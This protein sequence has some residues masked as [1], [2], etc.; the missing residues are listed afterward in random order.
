[1]G[2]HYRIYPGPVK[3]KGD[4]TINWSLPR[5][6][7]CRGVVVIRNESLLE[8]NKSSEESNKHFYLYSQD[9]GGGI[10]CYV[11]FRKFLTHFLWE[12]GELF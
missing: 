2:R 1:M 4:P 8:P 7:G 12:F 11:P 9:F 6:R 10:T 5:S 3:N